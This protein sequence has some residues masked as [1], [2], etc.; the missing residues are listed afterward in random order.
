METKLSIKHR[1]LISNLLQ[2]IVSSAAKRK[3]ISDCIMDLSLTVEEIKTTEYMERQI[4]N[5]ISFM[6]KASLDPMKSFSFNEIILDCLKKIFLKLDE[7]EKIDADTLPL[8]EMF[9]K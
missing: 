3:I 8:F 5:G 4:G 2:P 7:E 6:Y 9:T 1:I